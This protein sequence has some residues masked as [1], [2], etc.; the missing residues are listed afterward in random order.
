MSSRILQAL[1][2]ICHSGYVDAL[3]FLQENSKSWGGGGSTEAGGDGCI[4]PWWC[5]TSTDLIGSECPLRNVELA[6]REPCC[7]EVR[8]QHRWLDPQRIEKLPAEL[9]KGEARG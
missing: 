3:R 4:S 9:K 6:A 7:Q 1:A 5:P 8:N 2:E